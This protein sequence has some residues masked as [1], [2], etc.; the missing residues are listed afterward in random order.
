MQIFEG[1]F[2]ILNSY[3]KSRLAFLFMSPFFPVQNWFDAKAP[4]TI[5]SSFTAFNLY[6]L[7]FFDSKID[8][9]VVDYGDNL[10]KAHLILYKREFG[11]KYQ[12]G[13]VFCL[14][15]NSFKMLRANKCSHLFIKIHRGLTLSNHGHNNSL[16]W[17]FISVTIFCDSSGLYVTLCNSS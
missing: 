1:F 4:S 3:V 11:S 7:S 10:H 12:L 16:F 15:G 2:N 8:F 13:N 5:Q 17:L 14:I 9:V 6:C